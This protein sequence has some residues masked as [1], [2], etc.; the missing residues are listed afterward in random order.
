M[1]RLQERINWA[2]DN[3][4][5][6]SV[7]KTTLWKAARISSATVSNWIKGRQDSI[8]WAHA[9]AVAPLLGVNAQ[10]LYDGTGPRRPGEKYEASPQKD[11]VRVEDRARHIANAITSMLEAAGFEA[12][13]LGANGEIINTL[14]TKASRKSDESH[15]QE[16]AHVAIEKNDK[17][18]NLY[19]QQSGRAAQSWDVQLDIKP[20]ES[21]EKKSLG[22]KP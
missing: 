13:A 2:F 17:C 8:E 3:R 5:D 16:V 21:D 18:D 1:N 9:V 12:D 10:W 20:A 7:I 11:T 19:R 4:P 15:S 6:R 22:D 14:V